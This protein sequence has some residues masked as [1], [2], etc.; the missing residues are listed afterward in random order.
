[1]FREEEFSFVNNFSCNDCHQVPTGTNND[2]AVDQEG[3]VRPRRNLLKPAPFHELWKKHQERMTMSNGDVRGFLGGGFNHVGSSADLHAFAGLVTEATT[4]QDNLTQFIHQWDQGLAPAVHFGYLIDADEMLDTAFATAETYY[5]YRQA[6]DENCDSVVITY[7]HTAQGGPTARRWYM[8]RD[9]P[10]DTAYVCEDASFSARSLTDFRN[11]AAA[12]D[13]SSLFLGLPFGMGRR[14]AI[15][16]DQ[17]GVLNVADTVGGESKA[18]DP[19]LPGVDYG[20]TS[21]VYLEAPNVEWSSTR[22]A[23]LRFRTDRPTK[24]VI[25]YKED[26]VQP[27]LQTVVADNFSEVHTVMLKNLRPSTRHPG[28]TPQSDETCTAGSAMDFDTEIVWYDIL[29]TAYDRTGKTVSFSADKLFRSA[30]FTSPDSDAF[31]GDRDIRTVHTHVAQEVMVGLTTTADG[32]DVTVDIPI[33]FKQGKQSDLDSDGVPD[34]IPA[35]RRCVAGRVLI[36]RASEGGRLYTVPALNAAVGGDLAIVPN[37]STTRMAS[38]RIAARTANFGIP[39]GACTLPLL[40]SV[41]SDHQPAMSACDTCTTTNNQGTNIDF[42]SYKGGPFLI[43][44]HHTQASGVASLDFT[45]SDPAAGGTVLQTGDKIV[46]NIETVVEVDLTGT[47]TQGEIVDIDPTGQQVTFRARFLTPYVQ[48]SF[49]DT[50]EAG[51]SGEA[52]IP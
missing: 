19:T 21:P 48:W 5:I 10:G 28:C 25:R 50:T 27:T 1:M 17:D 47:T 15:D 4:E 30:D 33:V 51:V 32:H 9:I 13:E 43:T 14:W 34:P 45:V 3:G 8:E 52:M 42:W 40:E 31:D 36:S 6:R 35:P 39:P 22:M 7:D 23:R 38:C 24:Y 11:A 44:Y 49:P 37:L 20:G 12:G 2:I 16:Y 26:D 18:L 29:V 41:A 46:F